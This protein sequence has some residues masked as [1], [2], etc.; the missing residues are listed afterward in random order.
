MVLWRRVFA[1]IQ[2]FFS[3]HIAALFVGAALF[4][5][6]ILFIAL[7]LSSDGRLAEVYERFEVFTGRFPASQARLAAAKAK[8]HLLEER[9]WIPARSLGLMGSVRVNISAPFQSS[10]YGSG[11]LVDFRRDWLFTE[12]KLNFLKERTWIP[13]RS[14][15]LTGSVRVN[16]CPPF[17]SSSYGFGVQKAHRPCF[18]PVCRKRRSSLEAASQVWSLVRKAIGFEGSIS[19]T[20]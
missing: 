10:S 13:A 15:A 11:V 9:T 4:V 6:A 2:R 17:Q 12:R 8:L 1:Q 18:N 16:I 3:N 20:Q 19:F 14:L 5:T 7:F